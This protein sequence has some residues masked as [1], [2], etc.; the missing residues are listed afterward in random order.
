MRYRF[1]HAHRHEHRVMCLCGALRV[2]R[3]GYYDWVDRAPS[4]RALDN[5]TL[6]SAIRAVHHASR[7]RYGAVKTW[8]ALRERGFACGRNRVARL[9]AS[10]GIEA[11]RVRRFRVMVEHHKTPAAAPNH[12]DRRFEI[13]AANRVWM[14]D[15]TAIGTRAGWLYLAVLLDLYSRKVIGWAMSAKPDRKLVADAL[16]MAPTQREPKAGLLHHTDQGIQYR[17]ADYRELL[18]RHRMVPSMRR[19]G[20]CY[21]NACVESFFSTLKNELVEGRLY[22]TR[23]QART[24]IFEYIEIFYNRQRLHQ[25]LGYVSPAQFEAMNGVA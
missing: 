12:L 21:D 2:S 25:A 3:S 14:G 6:L 18:A 8:R 17:A 7:S 1:I 16:T 23:E 11:R 24:E 13:R 4:A 9:R 10:A 19:K 15:M 20:N 22:D 5:A